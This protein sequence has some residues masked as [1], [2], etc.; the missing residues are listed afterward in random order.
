MEQNT[1]QDN[2]VHELYPGGTV[3][4]RTIPEREGY[5]A[6]FERLSSDVTNLWDRQ[7]RLVGTEINEKVTTIKA[8]SGSMVVG[9]VIAFV[10]VFCLAATAIIGLASVIN[11]WLAAAAIVTV[12]LLVIGL[13][14]IKGAQ[15]KLTGR[16]LVPEHSIDALNQIKTTFQER[17]HEF[18][19]Q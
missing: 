9:G 14:M 1:Y 16:S 17:I 6:M 19:R 12:A 18:K 11:S 3:G 4:N 2:N 15:K 5:G 13:V 8:A 7:S 10:G